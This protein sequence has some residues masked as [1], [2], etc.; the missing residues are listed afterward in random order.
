M[1][2]AKVN[3]GR[4]QTVYVRA[5]RTALGLARKLSITCK[6]EPS[7]TARDVAPQPTQVK[8]S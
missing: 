4:Y 6:E 2:R 8:Q 5:A 7:V 3:V 1:G